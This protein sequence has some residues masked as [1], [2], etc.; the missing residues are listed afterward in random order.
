MRIRVLLVV[1][2]HVWVGKVSGSVDV[3][4]FISHSCSR[5][6]LHAENQ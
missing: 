6:L 3:F 4:L 1:I 5:F 2:Y